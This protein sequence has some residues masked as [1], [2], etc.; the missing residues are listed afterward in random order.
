MTAF[1]N[2]E[3]AAIRVALDRLTAED[4]ILAEARRVAG[5]LP[6]RRQ[7]ATWQSLVKLIVGQQISVAAAAAIWTRMLTAIEPFS[8]EELMS[9]D[10]ESLRGMGLSKTKVSY[11]RSLARA[12]IDGE[13]T[14]DRFPDMTDE[15]IARQLIAVRGIGKWTAEVF[16]LF[17]LERPDVFPADDLALQVAVQDLYGL[18]ERPKRPAVLE[19]AEQ[20]RPDRS[21]AA[22]LLWRYYGV[23]KQRQDPVTDG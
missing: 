20:W 7:P 16:L 18:S 5:I 6:E 12:E 8:A 11:C 2:G 1:R 10:D 13:L 17:A 4:S 22:R 15:E 21:T 3:T 9:H 23:V 19:I 14:I